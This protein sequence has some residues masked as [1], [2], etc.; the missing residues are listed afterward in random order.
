VTEYQLREAIDAAARQEPYTSRRIGN[1]DLLNDD[2]GNV[3]VI[4]PEIRQKVEQMIARE[5]TEA[6]N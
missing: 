3:S 5:K 6:N 2:A 1:C 4:T